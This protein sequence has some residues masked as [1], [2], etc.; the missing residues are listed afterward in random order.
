MRRLI[1]AGFRAID[2]LLV[3]ML[4]IMVV[5][6][7]ANVVLRYGFGSGITIYEEVSRFLFVWVTFLGAVSVMNQRGHLG[8]D[9]I[10][11]ALPSLG[12]RICH[13]LSDGLMLLCA[14]VFLWGAWQQTAINVNNVAPVSGIP[15]AFVYGS[16]VVSG[17][18][19]SLLIFADLVGALFFHTPDESFV[20]EA[21]EP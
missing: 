2:M 10:F 1:D 11:M 15:I 4:G 14:L 7:F 13:V 18:G 5:M 20:H 21:K 3:M 17:I 19:L 9:V 12:R 6:V 16:A 8:F